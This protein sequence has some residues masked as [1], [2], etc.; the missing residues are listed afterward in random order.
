MKRTI[1]VI[2]GVVMLGIQGFLP[3]SEILGLI[4]SALWPLCFLYAVCTAESTKKSWLLLPALYVGTVLRYLFTLGNNTTGIITMI[5]VSVLMSFIIFLVFFLYGLLYRKCGHPLVTLAFPVLFCGCL[6]LFSQVLHLGNIINPA[7]AFI[8]LNLFVQSAAVIG[9]LGI[10]FAVFFIMAVIIYLFGKGKRTGKIVLASVCLLLIVSGL[11]FG[12]VRL[13]TDQ[14]TT[15]TIRV[16][17]AM[18]LEGSFL[19]PAGKYPDQ[20]YIDCFERAIRDAADNN[21][22]ILVTNEEYAFFRKDS[23][24]EDMDKILRLVKKYHMP[25][26][27]CVGKLC[28]EDNAEKLENKAFLIDENGKILCEYNKH[29]RILLLETVNVLKGD[30]VPGRAVMFIKGKPRKVAVAICFDL[31]DELFINRMGDDMDLII[32]PSWDWEN[33][34]YTQPRFTAFRAIERN[35]ALIKT[36]FCGY[37]YAADRYGRIENAESTVG[38]FDRVIYMDVELH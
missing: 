4:A 36:T 15:E 5:V 2:L 19:E 27:F 38:Q 21:A 31:N 17:N 11:I 28:D 16:A 22:D 10:S 25:T 33:V 12:A 1:A 32:A 26:V 24:E 9:E 8:N 6:L 13:G 29:N 37:V 7:A 18:T 35:A 34:C 20:D 23:Y 3:T 14:G 30:D